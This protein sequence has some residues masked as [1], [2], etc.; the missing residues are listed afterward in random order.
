MTV[1]PGMPFMTPGGTEFMK[2]PA[3][4]SQRARLSPT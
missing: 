2:P 3:I 4:F 1:V